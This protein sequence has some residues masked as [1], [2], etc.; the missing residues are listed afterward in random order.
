MP[1][2]TMH[3]LQCSSVLQ[4]SC[5]NCKAR[6]RG[7]VVLIFQPAEERGQGAKDMIAEG[8][9]D[10]VDAIFGVHI[11]HLYPTGVVASRP[12]GEFLAG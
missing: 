12:A 7:T 11:V 10:N 3:V 9:L 8:V 1:E 6:C 5:S 2:A 4:G